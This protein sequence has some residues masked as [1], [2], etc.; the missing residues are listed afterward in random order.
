MTFTQGVEAIEAAAVPEPSTYA[1]LAGVLML[2][3]VVVR[4]RRS[5]QAE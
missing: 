2:G 5:S 1:L 4:R 3:L